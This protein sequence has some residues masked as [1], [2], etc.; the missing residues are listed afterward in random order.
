MKTVAP[1]GGG[2]SRVAAPDSDSAWVMMMWLGMA[3]A[4]IGYTDVIMN[5]IPAQWANLDWEFSTIG[6]TLDGMP[7]GTMGLGAATIA[8][9]AMG[10]GRPRQILGVLELVVAV[11]IVILTV[12]LLL[13]VP[14]LLRSV[15]PQARG[16]LSRALL[17]TFLEAV[18]L[19]AAYSVIGLRALAGA[20]E[21]GAAQ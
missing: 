6:A 18:V 13:E 15:E 16:L 12:I 21:K 17:K 19:I 2:A 1:R 11:I 10:W 5:W 14:V 8:A 20:R 7:L 9:A 4:V 3:A